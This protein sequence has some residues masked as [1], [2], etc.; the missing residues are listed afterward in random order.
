[1]GTVGGSGNLRGMTFWLQ[2]ACEEGWID[3]DARAGTATIHR[4]DQEVEVVSDEKRD[5]P[6]SY[7]TAH[8]LV[9][10]I[11]GVA[12]N[13]STAEVGWRAVELLDAAYRSAA[14][15]GQPVEIEQ[16]YSA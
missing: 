1:L 3:I 8:N 2:V 7:L 15:Q 10:I 14:R 11:N 16:L 12:E 5:V 9:E 6:T 4:A 13:G